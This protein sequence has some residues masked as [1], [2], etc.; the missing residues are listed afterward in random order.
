MNVSTGSQ[1]RGFLGH[2]SADAP[3]GK[4]LVGGLRNRT[5]PGSDII[6]GAVPASIAF[7]ALPATDVGEAIPHFVRCT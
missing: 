5:T 2:G 3:P 7:S 1:T 4:T 6:V